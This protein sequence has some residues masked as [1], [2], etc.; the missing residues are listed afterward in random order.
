MRALVAAAIAAL[1]MAGA[2][3]ASDV[4]EGRIIAERWCATCHLVSPEQE[5]AMD[6]VPSF[7]QI[8]EREEL[9]PQALAYYLMQP[10]PPMPDMALTRREIDKLVAYIESLDE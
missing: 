7:A 6:G 2:A 10:H 5:S 1:A 8:A 9:D 3:Q 4:R